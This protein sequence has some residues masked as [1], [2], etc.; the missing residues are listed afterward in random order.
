MIRRALLLSWLLAVSLSAAGCGEATYPVN[1]VVKFDGAPVAGATVTFC[2]DDGKTF[3]ASTDD[4]GNF[5]LFAHDK[6]GI[7]AGNYKVTVVKVAAMT[8]AVDGMQPSGAD[9]MK[10]VEANKKESD[11]KDKANSPMPRG[12][13]GMMKGMP[14]PGGGAPVSGPKSELPTQ[15]AS[16]TT[17][18][19]TFAVPLQTSPVSLDLEKGKDTKDAKKK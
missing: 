11:K 3:A 2:S 7:P 1:G 18:P 8:G 5:K 10:M 6:A 17:T 12:P 4:G 16:V 19:F 14:M 9:Y 13:G 15:Y